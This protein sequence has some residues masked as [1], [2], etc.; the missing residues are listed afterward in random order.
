MR[1]FIIKKTE[2]EDL[3]NAGKK[4]FVFEDG[5]EE[6]GSYAETEIVAYSYRPDLEGGDIAVIPSCLDDKVYVASIRNG[7]Y[8]RN[9]DGSN[10][11]PSWQEALEAARKYRDSLQPAEEVKISNPKDALGIKKAPTF[12]I[13]TGP[14]YEIGLAMMEGGRKYGAFNYRAVGVR[15]SVYYDACRRHLDAWK[16][17]E[18]IDPTSGIH[19]LMKAA[20]CL[21]VARDSMMMGNFED[22]RP[23]RYPKG[24]D[25]EE[26][27]KQAA[28]LIEK[29]PECKKPFTEKGKNNGNT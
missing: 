20:A 27:N 11:Y 1:I 21:I 17:G 25:M 28:G 18:D 5:H 19:H 15:A 7:D 29:Y 23:I 9:I 22:D 16:E 14:Q 13:P 2:N 8:V 12:V 10:E 3:R 6:L 24:M 4:Y 26:L